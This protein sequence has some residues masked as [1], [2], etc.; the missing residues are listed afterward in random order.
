MT[1][2]PASNLQLSSRI[3]PLRFTHDSIADFPV[4]DPNRSI[5]VLRDDELGGFWGSKYRKYASIRQH[6][7]N[8]NISNVIC[9][10]GINSNNL[11]AAAILLGEI[12]VKVT[13]FAVEDHAAAAL[14]STGNRLILKTALPPEQ[15]VLVPRSERD[16]ASQ[17]MEELAKKLL[18]DGKKCLVLQEGGGCLAA[19]P[20]SLTLADEVLRPRPEWPDNRIPEH[21]LIDSGT[22]LTAASLAAALVLKKANHLTKIHV[23]QMAGFEEQ[24]ENAVTTW[25]EPVTGVSWAQI[26]SFLRV[27]RP[28]SP[29]SYGATSTELFSFIQNMA[30]THGILTDPVY[31]AKLFLRA[32]DLIKGQNLKGKIVIVHTGGISGL[33]G[34][35]FM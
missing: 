9:T 4:H 11:A 23:V 17:R 28:L 33:L 12:G 3:T 15:L 6:C 14:P 26:M 32:F 29:R 21:I 8:E 35:Q 24:L 18:E 16:S 34:Y 7:L 20:G 2:W 22:G 5:W 27:Y 10:G 31:S 13:A 30:R 1:S 19:V 25:V